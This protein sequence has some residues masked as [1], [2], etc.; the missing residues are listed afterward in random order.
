MKD[1]N[2][3]PAREKSGLDKRKWDP[4]HREGLSFRTEHV[5]V[6]WKGRKA[7]YMGAVMVIG[8]KERKSLLIALFPQ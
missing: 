3:I 5:Q 1:R 6:I 4:M 7:K 2:G 8:R